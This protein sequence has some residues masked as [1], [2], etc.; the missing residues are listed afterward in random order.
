[1]YVYRIQKEYKSKE[2]KVKINSVL[3]LCRHRVQ[4]SKKKHGNSHHPSAIRLMLIKIMLIR[5]MVLISC[6][7]GQQE[8][9][10]TFNSL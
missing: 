6:N 3:V 7:M 8:K 2:K 4:K 9:G 10:Q 1:M 5:L